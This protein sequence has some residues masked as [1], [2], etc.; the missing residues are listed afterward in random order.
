M[1]LSTIKRAIFALLATT[2]AGLAVAAPSQAYVHQ[3]N[4]EQACASATLPSASGTM[5]AYGYAPVGWYN[6]AAAGPAGWPALV[7]PNRVSDVRVVVSIGWLSNLGNELQIE[8]RC[9]VRSTN[10]EDSG[11]YVYSFGQSAPKWT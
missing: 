6:A 8:E 3:A 9:D 2:G 5:S 11:I 10:G 4:A 1:R 7:G